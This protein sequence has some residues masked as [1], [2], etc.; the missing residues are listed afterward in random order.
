MSYYCNDHGQIME[1]EPC[2]LCFKVLEVRQAEAGRPVTYNV[3]KHVH[4][5]GLCPRCAER[6]DR[7][8]SQRWTLFLTLFLGFLGLI[9]ASY[10]PRDAS[11]ALRAAPFVPAAVVALLGVFLRV[12]KVHREQAGDPPESPAK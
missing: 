2:K 9:V 4:E 6:A 8:A 5:P 12:P 7:D 1:S 11:D 3:T 10:L